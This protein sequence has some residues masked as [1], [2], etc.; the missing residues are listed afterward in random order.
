MSNEK[1]QTPNN[2]TPPQTK[3]D[4][5]PQEGKF[6]GNTLPTF[7]APPPPPPPKEKK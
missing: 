1:Q 4:N 6:G 3:P 2:P 7:Q 5:T